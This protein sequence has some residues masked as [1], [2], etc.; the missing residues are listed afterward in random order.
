MTSFR[1][2]I[3]DKFVEKG[4]SLQ[5]YNNEIVK[6]IEDLC[7]KRDELQRSIILDEDEKRKIENDLQNLTDRL[8]KINESLAKKLCARNDFD[9]T[10][11]E[12]EDAY[13]KIVE[14]SLSLMNAAKR[15]TKSLDHQ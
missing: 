9:K 14:S 15:E 13:V 5:T 1:E 7:H 3:S 10:I 11:A 12:T 4:A 6:C 2:H 8:T